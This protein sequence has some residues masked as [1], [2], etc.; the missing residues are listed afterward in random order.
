M[1]QCGTHDQLDTPLFVVQEGGGNIAIL[2]LADVLDRP[3]SPLDLPP[4]SAGAHF[5]PAAG[6][7]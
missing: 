6:A 3:L 2:S 5:Q 4:D 7:G 1:G